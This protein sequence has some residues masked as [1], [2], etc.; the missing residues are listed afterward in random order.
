MKRRALIGS[1]ATVGALAIAGCSS[2]PGSEPG[3]GGGGGDG[4]G[5]GGGSGSD[6]GDAELY[7]AQAVT[8]L[9]AVALRLTKEKEAL[10]SDDEDVTLDQETLFGAIEEA[11]EK[12]DAASKDA[13]DT[14]TA[15]IETLRH[16]AT[17]LENQVE[18]L[19]LVE[20]VDT[21]VIADET[22]AAVE[23]RDYDTA[24][25]RVRDAQERAETAEE[26]A[27][28]AE[29]ALDG[30]DPD[31]LAA[32]DAVEYAKVEDG[33][34]QTA[35]LVDGF[36]VLTDSYEDAILGAQDLEAGRDDIDD[37]AFEAAEESFA[38][39]NEHFLAADETLA[40]ADRDYDEDVEANLTVASCQFT[41][42]IEAS[43]AFEEAAAYGSDGEIS[44]AEDRR[45]DGEDAYDEVSACDADAA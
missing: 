37:E 35:T 6:G 38:S 7:V 20:D 41:H 5:G 4:D 12:L 42:L 27:T 15:Q 40:T 28:N 30:V 2:D 44:K 3:D 22:Q 18:L 13:T 45:Q 43:E 16:L 33:V 36:V 23:D 17:V 31:R 26:Y 1:A 10:D 25:S 29:T 8:K 34:T 32:V 21:Q 39:A 19:V 14:Q 11:R 24:L 9:N